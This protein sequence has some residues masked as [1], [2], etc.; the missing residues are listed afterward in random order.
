[1]VGDAMKQELILMR[2]LQV[3]HGVL[4]SFLNKS[5]LK[6]IRTRWV[7]TNKGDAANPFIRARLVAQECDRVSEL[8]SEDAS[9]MSSLQS[10]KFMLRR[11]MIANWRAPA[12]VKVLDSALLVALL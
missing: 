10:L 8:R 4:V 11:C 2:K 3:Y 7:Y 9:S 1:M 6:T 5:G 12:D